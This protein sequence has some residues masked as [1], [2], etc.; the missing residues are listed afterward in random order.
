ML[1]VAAF[2]RW[3]TAAARCAEITTQLDDEANMPISVPAP[4]ARSFEKLL[5][6][7]EVASLPW[8]ARRRCGARLA[9]PTI[10]RWV[11]KGA[12]AID[13]TVV[14]LQTVRIG[15]QPCTTEEWLRDFFT[16]LATPA[17]TPVRIIP[18]SPVRRERAVSATKARLAAQGI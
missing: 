14:R 6:L 18:R 17:D 7:R 12:R 10:W 5:P 13:G 2:V 16:A 11:K 15:S 8:L 9:Y 1:P 3:A 4:T